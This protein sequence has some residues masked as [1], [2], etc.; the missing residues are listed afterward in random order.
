MSS[1]SVLIGSSN[2]QDEK[3]AAGNEKSME[4]NWNLA[5]IGR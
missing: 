4:P 1:S 2:G 3:E 5:A